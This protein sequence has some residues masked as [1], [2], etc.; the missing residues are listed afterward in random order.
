MS[1]RIELRTRPNNRFAYSG[2]SVLVTNAEG[3]ITG[4]NTEG[5]F[6]KD[7]RLISKLELTANDQPATPI[8]ASQVQG[9]RFLA[10]LQIPPG[11]HTPQ[12][13]VYVEMAYRVDEGMS[14]QLRLQNYAARETAKFELA[15]HIASDFADMNELAEGTRH[16]KASVTTDWR[17]QKQELMISYLHPDL[18]R[19]VAIRVEQAPEG[20]TYKENALVIPL[21]LQPHQPTGIRLAIEPVFDDKRG[22]APGIFGEGATELDALRSN[23]KNEAP[24]L[25]TTNSTVARAWETAIADLASLPLGLPGGPAAPIGGI[26][27]YQRLFGRDMLT[28]AWQSLL[29]MPTMTRDAL[30]LNAEWQGSTIDDWRDEE[31]GKFIHQARWGPLSELNFDP[32][33]RYY[34]DYAAPT[35]FLAFLGQYVAW[36]NDIATVREL[37]PAARSAIDWLDRYGDLDGDGFLEYEGRSKKEVK[38]QGWKDSP[39]A[40]VDVHGEIVVNPIAP[41]EIQAYWYAGL[42][43][44]A[45]AFTAAGDRAYALDLVKKASQ[46]K[47]RFNKAFWMGDESFYALGLGPN[48]EQIRSITSNPGHLLVSGIVPKNRAK[49]VAKRLME[50]DMFSGWGIRTLSAHHKA[51]NPFSYHLG[52]VWPVENGTFALGFGR[53]GL[54]DE[55]HRLTEGLFAMTELFTDNRLPEAVGGLPRDAAHPHPGIYPQSNIPQ[56]WSASMVPVLIQSFLGMRPAAPLGVLLIDPHLPEWL[57][58]V[59]LKGIRVGQSKVDLKVWR[60]AKGKTRYKITG[61]RGS[62]RVV[63][64]PPVLSLSTSLSGRASAFLTSLPRL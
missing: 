61:Q 54:F 33:K 39:D 59:H 38:N 23:L 48:K 15:L 27:M 28:T 63:R 35:D 64:Q 36:T 8:I 10:Y 62:V 41:C 1:D 50:P 44:A 11:S 14:I 6:Y 26:P 32:V 40:V 5:F 3:N 7:T 12:Q 60:T 55:L 18:Q 43:Q 22:K 56:A 31:P 49:Q 47:R 42:R 30:R 9:N 13:G 25:I 51:Y 45:F 37:L 58:D 34:G 46:L 57:P 52:S 17:K 4:E 24:R 16:Q 29:A 20:I 21:T 2:C 53:Y 19:A